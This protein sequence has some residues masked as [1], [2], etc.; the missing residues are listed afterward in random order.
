MSRLLS[1]ISI[2]RENVRHMC[3]CKLYLII[4]IIII[5]Y[6][7]FCILYFFFWGGGYSDTLFLPEKVEVKCS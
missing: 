7:V 5:L 1:A 4:I 2:G 6:F 3:I